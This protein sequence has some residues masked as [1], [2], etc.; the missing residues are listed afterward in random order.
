MTKTFERLTKTFERLTKTFEKLTSTF[1]KLTSTFEKLTQNFEK[2]TK[3]FLIRVTRSKKR[4]QKALD[5]A[6]ITNDLAQSVYVEQWAIMK[7]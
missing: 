1:E 2:L 7:I 4:L 6:L 5:F 3:F